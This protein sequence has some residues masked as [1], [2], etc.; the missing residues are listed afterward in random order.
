MTL[1]SCD[2]RQLFA[3]FDAGHSDRVTSMRGSMSVAQVV[4]EGIAAPRPGGKR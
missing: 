2:F 1:A 4:I 3:D